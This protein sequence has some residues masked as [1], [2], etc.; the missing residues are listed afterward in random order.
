MDLTETSTMTDLIEFK[1]IKGE[2]NKEE[3]QFM[4]LSLINE[5][6][7]FHQNQNFSTIIKSGRDKLHSTNRIEELKNVKTNLNGFFEQFPMDS[8]YSIEANI[9]I[10][11]K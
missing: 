11:K 2:F 8:N 7:K 3:V 4:L 10:V 5:K 9:K 1:L 6:I